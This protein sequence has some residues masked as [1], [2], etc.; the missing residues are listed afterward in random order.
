MNGGCIQ[1][2]R[3]LNYTAIHI[4]IKS[5]TYINQVYIYKFQPQPVQLH[6]IIAI[7]HNKTYK[8][9]STETMV[10]MCWSNLLNYI[11]TLWGCAKLL[12]HQMRVVVDQQVNMSIYHT[13]Q[14]KAFGSLIW[15][16]INT[17]TV[18]THTCMCVLYFYVVK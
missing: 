8:A 2:I 18:C 3:S 16:T 1:K 15:K 12:G 7:K 4:A 11:G 17:P 14:R 6:S 13:G 10:N 5:V 9:H